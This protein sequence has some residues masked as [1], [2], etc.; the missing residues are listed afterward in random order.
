MS[1]HSSSKFLLTHS[2]Q[3]S[4][5]KRIPP[6]PTHEATFRLIRTNSSIKVRPNTIAANMVSAWK[7]VKQRLFEFANPDATE[8]RSR[9]NPYANPAAQDSKRKSKYVAV[10]DD[11][12]KSKPKR[13]GTSPHNSRPPVSY[14]AR[15]PAPRPTTA[16]GRVSSRSA[17]STRPVTPSQLPPQPNRPLYSRPS[18]S[19]GV[20]RTGSRRRE[21]PQYRD[22]SAYSTRPVAPSQLPPQPHRPMSSRP[23]TSNNGASRTG[24]RPWD[25]PPYRPQYRDV[26]DLREASRRALLV[27]NQES[28]FDD[29]SSISS[30]FTPNRQYSY[31]QQERWP[32]RNSSRN[33]HMTLLPFC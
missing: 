15:T 20:S 23:S 1:D 5:Q 18:T 14:V 24:R 22:V 2:I 12:P 8:I 31:G 33:W 7:K 11:Q 13:R 16:D 21:Q 19:N 25:Q 30:G 3:G 17:Y 29:S 10:W 6:R 32:P 9:P 4:D 27:K 28:W 26:A